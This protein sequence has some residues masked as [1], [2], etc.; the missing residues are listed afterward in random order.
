[1][2]GSY[3]FGQSKDLSGVYSEIATAIDAVASGARGIVTYP[4]TAAWGPVNE[5][6]DV[7][8]QADFASVYAAKEEGFTAKK[9]HDLA[10]LG[11][12]SLVLG[13][14]LASVTAAAA[15]IV[16]ADGWELETKYP[17]ELPFV[18]KVTDALTGGKAIEVTL[19]GTQVMKV[20]GATPDALAMAIDVSD[21]LRVKTKGAALPENVAGVSA[22][23]GNNGENV[24]AVE[25]AAYRETIE[26]D[27]RAKA[28]ALDSYADPA[29]VAAT[30]AWLKRVREEGL[31]ISFVNGGP[32]AWDADLDAANTVSKDYNYRAIVNV[33]NGVDGYSAGEMA[34]FI[35]ARV[36]SVALNRQLTDEVIPFQQVNKKL[37][38]SK[39]ITAKRAGTLIF[40]QKGDLVEIDEAVN[41][42]TTVTDPEKQRIE[43]GKIRVSNTIDQ[44]LTD[45]EAF[46]GQYKKN[47][48]NTENA[49]ETYAAL[50][51]QDYF[52]SLIGQDVLQPGATYRPDADYHGTDA[53]YKAK[54]DEAFFTAAFKV[55][56]G[57]E[58]V[59]QK[60]NISF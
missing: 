10:F 21:Y 31:Y 20:S 49:R 8:N 44:V 19:N 53:A 60:M 45:T 33:G 32:H 13:Y 27:G 2:S 55:V 54:A 39:R 47:R 17:T 25:Y 12:P 29:E 24:T 50:I 6:Q 9:V 38:Q 40:V 42:F 22:I 52:G 1:M 58:K 30:V 59:Y 34:I 36:A 3:Q 4:F 26:A 37:T 7:Y 57:M 56:D 5:L 18:A 51:E 23:G 48:S 15:T 35:A 16:L 11:L 43:F 14:R 41:T 28:I 46:G